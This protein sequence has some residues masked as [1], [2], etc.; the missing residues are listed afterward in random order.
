M[1]RLLEFFLGSILVAVFTV[2]LM[3]F[4][5]LQYI[6]RAGSMDDCAWYGSARTWIDSNADG[7]VDRGEPLL[8]DV[9]IHVDDVENQLV[10]VGWPARTDQ[11]GDAQFTI[12]IPGCLDTVFE[13]YVDVPEGFR[14]TTSPRISIDPEV[15]RSPGTERVYYFGF[16][17]DR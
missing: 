16:I 8:A 5:A 3:F 13:I 14:M 4:S 17:L 15:W 12:P 7:R 10:D 2:A 11:D 1:S 6:L 9:T